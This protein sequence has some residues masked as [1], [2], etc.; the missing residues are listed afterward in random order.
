MMTA[1]VRVMIMLFYQIFTETLT[2]VKLEDLIL[3]QTTQQNK[4]TL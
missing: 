4:A 3:S 1:E 2:V